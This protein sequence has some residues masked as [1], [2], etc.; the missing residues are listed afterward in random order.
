MRESSVSGHSDGWSLFTSPGP[1]F[2][3]RLESTAKNINYSLSWARLL[4]AKS[5][6]SIISFYPQN[7]LRFFCIPLGNKRLCELPKVRELLSGSA[8]IQNQFC[9]TVEFALLHDVL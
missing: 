8:R 1:T 2:L 3:W 7:N 5:F 4:C 9:L 6:A